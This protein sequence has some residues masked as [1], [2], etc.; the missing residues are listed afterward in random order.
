MTTAKTKKIKQTEIGE[1]PID[2]GVKSFIE[3][4]SD[5]WT[6][7]RESER[8]GAYKRQG[9]YP[10][11]DQGKELIA[12]Y[13][14]D[15]AKVYKD[16]IPL[17]VFGDHTR[18]F[19]YI[20]FPFA[21]GADGTKLLKANEGFNSKFL[22]YV[23][24]KLDIPNRGYN[25]HYK[26]LK[27]QLI[28]QP[29]K[30]EQEKIAG[31]LS[32]LQKAVENQ[33]KI[34][35][36]LREL[37]AATIAKLFREGL[38]GEPLKNTEIGEVPGGWDVKTFGE[39]VTL[40][41]GHD[42]P[43]QMREIGDIP[44]IGSN[45]VVGYHKVGAYKGPGVLTGRSGTIG[46]SFYVLNEYW[47]LNTALFVSDFHGNNPKF[48]HYFFQQFNFKKYS[49]GVSVPTLNRNLVHSAVIASPKVE[50]QQDIAKIL[51]K[52]DESIAQSGSKMQNMQNLFSSTLNQLMTGKVRVI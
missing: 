8:Q 41:R 12:G 3:A 44:V 29:P 40:Q 23:F 52:I 4:I 7:S 5:N 31:L 27:E 22:Y 18:I 10:I 51:S 25:R 13:T 28:P 26:I 17:I 39:F 45:G 16:S 19:K 43:V 6:E 48:V 21:T 50:E 42:L 2:W 24:K 38:H 1:I 46:L 37:K 32:K 14:D 11:V 49:G 33:E 9:R 15:E 30:P 20:D 36:N 34:V 47:P 35:A